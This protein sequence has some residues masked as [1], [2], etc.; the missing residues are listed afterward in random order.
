MGKEEQHVNFVDNS[1]I[2]LLKANI[3]NSFDFLICT[4]PNTNEDT[5]S[6]SCK[7]SPDFLMIFHSKIDTKYMFVYLTSLVMEKS[8][9]AY[10]E[11]EMLH[12]FD[13]WVFF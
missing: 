13:T 12:H 2:S 1:L 3:E 8:P 9:L 11:G 4:Y 7:C 10:K 6:V 5:Y